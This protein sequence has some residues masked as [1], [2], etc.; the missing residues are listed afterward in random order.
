[1]AEMKNPNQ[2]IGG[3]TLRVIATVILIAFIALF[4]QQNLW[5]TATFA[6][7][8]KSSIRTA[9]LQAGG[10]VTAARV[11]TIGPV[12]HAAARAGFPDILARPF[13][14]ILRWIQGHV[15]SNWGWAILLLTLLIQLVLMPIRMK[16]MRSQL[17][18]Q[19]I[20]PEIATIK[21]RFKGCKIGDARMQ[22]MNQEIADLH[23]ITA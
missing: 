7:Q 15:V 5:R 12:R 22:T 14:V 16:S 17:G 9:Q 11:Q 20:Q 21:A 23:R 6:P 18:M 8:A 1:M 3:E 2:K 13:F 4:L 19:R 10:S